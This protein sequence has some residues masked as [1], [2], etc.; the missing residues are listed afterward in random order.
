MAKVKKALQASS[1]TNSKKGKSKLFDIILISLSVVF[2]IIGM[3][4]IMAI[5]PSSGY[6]AV[7]LAMVCFFYYYIRKG[8]R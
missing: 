3:Y 5:G 1:S 8:G 2:V 4:E 6:W 7:M